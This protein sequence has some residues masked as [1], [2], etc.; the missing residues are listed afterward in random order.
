MTSVHAGESQQA[1]IIAERLEQ[2]RTSLEARFLEGGEVLTHTLDSIGDMIGALDRVTSSLGKDTVDGTVADLSGTAAQIDA[3]PAHQQERQGRMMRLAN[4]SAALQGDVDAMVETLRYLRTFAI[5]A[6]VTAAGDL[7]FSHF[8]D[9]MLERINFGCD[10][11]NAFV[12]QLRALN[13]HLRTAV[14]NGREVDAQYRRVVPEVTRNLA[15]DAARMGTYHG[16]VRRVTDDLAGLVR[17]VQSKVARILSSL[18]IGDITRQRVEHVQAGLDAEGD[19]N[20]R[21][22][23]TALQSLQMSDILDEFQAGTAV[24]TTS[25]GGLAA[26]VKE[27]VALG[28]Q[29]R[30]GSEGSSDGFLRAL[31]RSVARARE[32][33]GGIETARRKADELSSSTAETARRLID[34]VDAIR[35]I[36][37]EIQYMSINTSL[38]CSRMG[39]AG[40]P[41]NVVALELRVFADQM[42]RVADRLVA[43]LHRLSEVADALVAGHDDAPDSI[44][45]RLDKAL[46]TIEGA[47][48]NME[49]DLKDLSARGDL[50]ARAVGSS[51][52]KLDFARELGDVLEECAYALAQLAADLGEADADFAEP[53]LQE[54][55][56]LHFRI[57]TMAR[58]RTIHRSL[59]TAP[60]ATADA[61]V[62]VTAAASANAD[63]DLDDVLF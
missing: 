20:A 43:G 37:A 3:L 19:A 41:M 63:A 56:E 10:T 22:A 49:T 60:D 31:E 9:E 47:G 12:D 53:S 26:N 28:R 57:Y 27:I 14:S 15:T 52:S 5:T 24:V 36:R 62:V 45:D 18:Q 16:E 55:A 2:A 46:V 4:A 11:V 7:D 8:A 38:R 61:A 21:A 33:A 17:E 32:L 42:E 13:D 40:K 25:L 44:C 35:T 1:A 30:G 58:E 34:S 51:V 59:F 50:V 29:A 6:K 48:A 54:R 23:L 39:E